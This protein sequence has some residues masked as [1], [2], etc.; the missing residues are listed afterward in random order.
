MATLIHMENFRV[1]AVRIRLI[2]IGRGDIQKIQEVM[3]LLTH[4]QH[5]TAGSFK[6]WPVEEYRESSS[7]P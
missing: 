3:D 7:A 5:K 4:T 2:Q 6:V 1:D